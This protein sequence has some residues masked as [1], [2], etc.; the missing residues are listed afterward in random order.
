MDQHIE[1]SDINETQKLLEKVFKEGGIQSLVSVLLKSQEDLK[2]EE[3][4]F[5]SSPKEIQELLK[6]LKISQ[7]ELDII[8]WKLWIN[9][10]KEVKEILS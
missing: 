2:K 6:P 5:P 3:I 10:P 1:G 8:L 7:E 4:V 9:S